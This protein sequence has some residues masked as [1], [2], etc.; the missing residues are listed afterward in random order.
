VQLGNSVKCPDASI[1]VD[2]ARLPNGG[3]GHTFQL[4]PNSGL[5]NIPIICFDVAI[6]NESL[7]TLLN[8]AERY[9]QP[10]TATR[11]W[12]GIKVFHN[13]RNNPPGVD[14]WW[15]GHA[16]RDQD[17]NTG[18]W[19]NTYTFQAGSMTR[20]LNINADINVAVP[21]LQFSVSLATLLHPLPIPPGYAPHLVFDLEEFRRRIARGL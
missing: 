7:V 17:P 16:L 12:I 19:L 9:F 2:P 3:A 5:M 14:T 6:G 4:D 8:D 18:A 15:A 13:S 21:G 10:G 1:A 20:N 11:Y